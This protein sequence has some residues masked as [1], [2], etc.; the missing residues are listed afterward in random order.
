MEPH[1]SR[2]P[3]PT[4]ALPGV[5]ISQ[6]P[7]VPLSSH[8]FARTVINSA[9]R[10]FDPAKAQANLKELDDWASEFMTRLS[11]KLKNI[12]VIGFGHAGTA[13]PDAG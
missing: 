12:S 1:L 6:Q 4:S 9:P 13:N 2:L 10:A 11:A 3:D 7:P 5:H 8:S